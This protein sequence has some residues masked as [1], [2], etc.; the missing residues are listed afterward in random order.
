[1]IKERRWRLLV[2]T[3]ILGIVGALSARLFVYIL[4]FTQNIFLTQLAGYQPPGL[5]NEAGL[6][7]QLIGAHGIWLIPLA[8]TLGGLLSG[9][10]VYSL[11]PEAEGH[12]T[13]T[14][15]KAFHRAGG[16]IRAR[17]NHTQLQSEVYFR[18]DQ[19]S[20]L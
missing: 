5:P 10:L 13:D 18:L 8:T 6:H 3:L 12:S 20:I 15:I 7:T 19:I 17:V 4:K 14:V 16:F 2:D 1:M 11:A 9:I